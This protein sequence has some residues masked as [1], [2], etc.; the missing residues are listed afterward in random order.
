MAD[1]TVTLTTIEEKVLE[2]FFLDAATAVEL[3]VNRLVRTRAERIIFESTS[4]K[5]PRKMTLAE[6][7]DELILI[8]AEVPTYCERHPEDPSC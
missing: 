4:V 1:Y 5:D 7:R 3:A 6:L 2:S 8:Q